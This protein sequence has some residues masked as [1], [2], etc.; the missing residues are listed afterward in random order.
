[1]KTGAWRVVLTGLSLTCVTATALFLL[2][3]VN[4][5]DAVTYGSA[6]LVYAAGS[7]A[8]AIAFNRASVWLPRRAESA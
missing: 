5:K 8:L 2:V 1:M 3:A 4:P 7:A 6:P